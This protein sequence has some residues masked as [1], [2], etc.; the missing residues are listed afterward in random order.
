MPPKNMTKNI[1]IIV[2]ILLVII[3]SIFAL[4]VFKPYLHNPDVPEH[5]QLNLQGNYQTALWP[6]AATYSIPLEVP[7]GRNGLTPQISLSYNSHSTSQRPTITGTA[8]QLSQNY[9]FRDTNFNFE[10]AENDKFNLVLNGETHELV[11]VP[12]ENRYHT[13]K[14]T[15]L[16][17]TK[18]TGA[19]NQKSEY[20]QIK[21]P[22]GTTYRFGYNPDSELV[23]NTY[24]YVVKWS[25][26]LIKDTHNNEIYYTYTENPTANDLGAVYPSKIEYNNEKSRIIEF[27]LEDYDRPDNWLVY[28]NGNK[29]RESRRIKEIIINANSK[30]VRKYVLNYATF[31]T[32]AKSFLS[33]I[34]IVGSDGSTSLPPI[35]FEYNQITKGWTSGPDWIIPEDIEFGR[36]NDNGVRLLD[37]NR[38]GLLDIVASNEDIE[39]NW[40]NNGK[41]WTRDYRWNFPYYDGITD[42]RDDDT[43]IRFLELDGDGFIDIIQ[44]SNADADD[45][46]AWLNTGNDWS[47]YHKWELPENAHPIDIESDPEN[48]DRGVRFEDFN[49]DG[50]TDILMAAGSTRRAW[51]NI[52]SGWNL[53]FAW[54]PPS[55]IEFVDSLT[56]PKDQGVRVVDVNGDNLPD[57]L[58]ADFYRKA[59]LNNG[60]GWTRDDSYAVPSGISFVHGIENYDTGIRFADVNGDGLTDI[61]SGVTDYKK[62]WLN[63]GTGWV[64]DS[65][66][67]IPETALFVT[68]EGDNKGVRIADVNGDGLPDI[69]KAR[70]SGDKE[71]WINKA[72]KAYLLK[73]ITTEYGGKITIQYDKSTT[74]K[75]TGEDAYPDLGFNLWL[76]SKV[77]EDNGITSSLNYKSST[78]YNYHDGKYDYSN[79]ELLGFANVQELLSSQIITNHWYHQTIP[80][81][82]KEYKLEISDTATNLFQT[83]ELNYNTISKDGYYINTLDT[84]NTFQYDVII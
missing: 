14:E 15:F 8:W 55:D 80:L 37:L 53:D 59:W 83:H 45:R 78:G 34:T 41:G 58:L 3:P 6:G 31:D 50:R 25:L 43:G 74:I 56:N 69:V 12:A 38:D 7:Q 79:K 47:R 10:G 26:D 22:D 67:K 61:I 76:V 11:Y 63:T 19:P 24:D 32:S 64:E 40:L 73:T 65:D 75:N 62:T 71:T 27:K 35:K 33:D 70:Y 72:E 68:T 42:T 20:W 30:L 21:T 77:D 54:Y 66:W 28:E 16:H 82:G 23:S 84:V 51:K 44:A 13:K 57:I 5:P 9:I 49:G 29:I 81:A 48:Y 36:S 60:Y 52:D 39:E 2:G 46:Y 1:V 17:I 4:D 18:T